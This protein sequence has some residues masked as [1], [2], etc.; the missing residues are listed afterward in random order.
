MDDPNLVSDAAALRGLAHPFRLQLLGLLRVHGP[1]TASRLAKRTGESS[2]LTSYHLRGLAAAGHIVDAKDSDLR[3][4]EMTGG[5]ERW[6][7]AA[8]SATRTRPPNAGDIDEMA[9]DKDFTRAVVGRL[10][11]NADRW[12]SVRGDWP[13]KWQTVADISDRVLRLNP[14]EAAALQSDMWNLAESYRRHD[15]TATDAP[16]D[17]IVVS[18]QYQ[19]FPYP[20]Q[21]IPS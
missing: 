15:P 8:A 12:V 21:T 6:W 9:A 7:K 20:D 10:L 5:R 1:S 11:H 17:A 4:V 3:S 13:E 19:L 14:A 18:L 16:D 2:A